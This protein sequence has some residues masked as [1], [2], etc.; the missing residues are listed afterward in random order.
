MRIKHLIELLQKEV[1][2]DP[3]IADLRLVAEFDCYG[4]V[5]YDE[6]EN[7]ELNEIHYDKDREIFTWSKSDGTKFIYLD[8]WPLHTDGNIAIHQYE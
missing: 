8:I 1:E 6:V 2:K 7:I 5:R 3:S 4:S